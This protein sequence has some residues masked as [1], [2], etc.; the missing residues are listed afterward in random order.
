MV[1]KII[2][3]NSEAYRQMIDLRIKVLLNPIG[4]PSSFIN[5][6]MEKEDVLI[7][8]FENTILIGCCVLSKKSNDTIQLRQM[9]VETSYQR[10]GVG[11]AIVLFA[12][13]WAK[14]NGFETMLLHA[15]D[16]VINFY[17]KYGYQI[18]GDG[19]TEVN[20]PHHKMK[21]VL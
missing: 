14:E 18:T 10:K 2:E 3:H 15:R 21:K 13:K 4:V 1:I 11:A 7:G 5:Q 19:F 12:E 17:E 6:P 9:A 16:R 20:I 8:A